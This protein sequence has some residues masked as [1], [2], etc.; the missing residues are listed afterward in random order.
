MIN[1]TS[2]EKAQKDLSFIRHSDILKIA[3]FHFRRKKKEK[4]DRLLLQPI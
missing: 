4:K 1:M 2:A 3:Y